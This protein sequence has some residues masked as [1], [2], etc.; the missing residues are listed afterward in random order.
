MAIKDVTEFIENFQLNRA[1][2]RIYQFFNIISKFKTNDE[3]GEKIISEAIRVAIRIIEP[4][5]PHLAE[6][7][8]ESLGNKE[9]LTSEE[10]PALDDSLIK[11][12]EA[13]VVIQVNGKRRAQISVP[14]N[15]IE[16]QIKQK[17]LL[18]SNVSKEID[19]KE[20][21]KTIFVPNK[22]LNIVIKSEG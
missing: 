1:V 5:M 19:G 21:V 10:W 7:C 15:T 2:A 12:N 13:T 3:L 16:D 18:V 9:T 4:M 17:A 20:I 8:W 6:E 14:N 22:I 11:Q